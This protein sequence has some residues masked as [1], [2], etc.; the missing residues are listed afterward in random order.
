M[1][2]LTPIASGDPILFLMLAGILVLAGAAIGVG[3]AGVSML[4]GKSDE[5]K[6]LGRRLLSFAAIPIVV[7]AGWWIA[8]VGFD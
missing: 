1:R 4:F 5:K 3:A 6:K 2:L 7:A 8:V